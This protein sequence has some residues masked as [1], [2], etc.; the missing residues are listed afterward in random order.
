[1]NRRAGCGEKTFRGLNDAIIWLT[2]F[3]GRGITLEDND[4]LF[5]PPRGMDLARVRML[6]IGVCGMD[7]APSGETQFTDNVP[8][9][10]LQMSSMRRQTTSSI[11]FCSERTC[12]RATLVGKSRSSKELADDR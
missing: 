10:A 4:Q 2:L 5:D 7:C 11:Y 3:S 6:K 12:R 8:E 1:M 9:I